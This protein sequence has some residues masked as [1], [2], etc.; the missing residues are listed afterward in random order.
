MR[1]A[2]CMATGA[3]LGTDKDAWLEWWQKNK[4]GFKISPQRP[5]LPEELEARWESYW[6]EP[7]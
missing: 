4:K 5:R 2:L 3:D 6:G 7:Y 1:L